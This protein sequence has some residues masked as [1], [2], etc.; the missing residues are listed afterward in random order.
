[1]TGRA[2]RGKPG[3]AFPLSLGNKETQKTNTKEFHQEWFGK[4]K[5]GKQTGAG[6]GADPTVN[7]SPA[8]LSS[9]WRRGDT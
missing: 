6:A 9:V 3:N 8:R 4:S 5:K 2:P 1:M 7:T